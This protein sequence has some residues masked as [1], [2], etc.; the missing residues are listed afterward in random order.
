MVLENIEDLIRSAILMLTTDWEAAL[1]W[2][3]AIVSTG[4]LARKV[5]NGLR[6]VA[7]VFRGAA[8][9]FLGWFRAR[10]EQK[11]RLAEA[12]SEVPVTIVATGKTWDSGARVYGIDSQARRVYRE[13]CKAA[14]RVLGANGIGH[15]GLYDGVGGPGESARLLSIAMPG[16]VVRVPAPGGHWASF[17]NGAKEVV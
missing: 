8:Q 9:R 11:M 14:K 5:T 10:K 17:L 6:R 2:L 4:W 12:E 16:T 1:G 3:G 15:F 13:A 7:G